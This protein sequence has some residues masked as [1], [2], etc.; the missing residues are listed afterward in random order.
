MLLYE[1]LP[2]WQTRG[3]FGDMFGATNALISSLALVGVVYSIILQ[4][5]EFDSTVKAMTNQLSEMEISRILSSQPLPVVNIQK[6]YIENPR[7]YYTP[8]EKKHEMISR[9]F[10]KYKIENKSN[11]V[12]ADININPSLHIQTDNNQVYLKS[13]GKHVSVLSPQEIGPKERDIITMFNDD[14]KSIIFDSLRSGDLPI[15]EVNIYYQN[16]IGGYFTVTQK[17]YV[18]VQDEE[19]DEIL[20]KWHS[21]ISSFS[22]EYKNEL[23]ELKKLREQN[24][25]EKWSSNFTELQEKITQFTIDDNLELSLTEI[26][27]TFGVTILNKDEYLQ[28]I[29]PVNFGRKL[30]TLGAQCPAQN[31]V[32]TT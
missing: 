15:F 2:D 25:E 18:D 5:N 10:F 6:C 22:I 1:I 13:S 7:L 29:S 9:Y 19:C 32:K 23:S 8:P 20:K 31:T 21:L 24:L 17:Y 3:L 26:P 12:V 28:R 11:F 14:E 27:G 4:R 30:P 16:I